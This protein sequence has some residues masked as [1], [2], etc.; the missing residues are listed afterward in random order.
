[1]AHALA[2]T[3]PRPRRPRPLTTLVSTGWWARHAA[4]RSFIAT[5]TI[6]AYSSLT[7]AGPVLGGAASPPS[8]P[9]AP[10]ARQAAGE[11]LRGLGTVL[12]GLLGGVRRR[13]KSRCSRPSPRIIA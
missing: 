4:L 5:L 9:V 7:L 12:A 13:R 6:V 1:M 2:L 10:A 8:V 11:W 3:L